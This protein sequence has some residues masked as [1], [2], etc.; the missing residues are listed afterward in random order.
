MA[1]YSEAGRIVKAQMAADRRAEERQK[2]PEGAA[3]TLHELSKILVE[4]VA[5]LRRI[6]ERFD[7]VEARISDG[8]ANALAADLATFWQL[9]KQ[10]GL[11]ESPIAKRISELLDDLGEWRS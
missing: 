5:E 2:R 3:P 9:Y 8:L 6:R 4:E 10:A 1:D 11:E 7:T